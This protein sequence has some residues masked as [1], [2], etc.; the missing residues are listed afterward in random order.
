MCVG[1]SSH[2]KSCNFLIVNHFHFIFKL[3]KINFTFI[4]YLIFEIKII[5]KYIKILIAGI[6]A[7]EFFVVIDIVFSKEEVTLNLLKFGVEFIINICI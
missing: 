6:W 7:D 3:I 4:C 2:V 1:T 5:F